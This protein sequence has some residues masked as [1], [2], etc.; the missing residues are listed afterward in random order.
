[1]L[2]L[3][4]LN[5]AATLGWTPLSFYSMWLL[6]L[7]NKMFLLFDIIVPCSMLLL[8]LVQHHYSFC[9]MSMLL[10]LNAIAPLVHCCY[11]HVHSSL[12][13]LVQIT[14]YYIHDVVTP[15]LTLLLLLLLFQIGI[16]PPFLFFASVGGAIQIQ[17]RQARLG[18]WDFFFNLCLLMNFLNYPCFWEMLVDNVFVYCV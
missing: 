15:C 16:P 8:F 2:L 12:M 7:L 13:R 14:L 18:R 17:V 9:S 10:L 4:L 3:L 6:F 11:S 1:M 5:V